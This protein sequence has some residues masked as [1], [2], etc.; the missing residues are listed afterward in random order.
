MTQL[1]RLIT[2]VLLTTLFSIA[3]YAFRLW[4]QRTYEG[5]DET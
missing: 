3:L 2:L 5:S 1:K 4:R